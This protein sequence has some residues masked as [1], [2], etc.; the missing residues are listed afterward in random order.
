MRKLTLVFAMVIAL[1][2]A[3]L[4][5]AHGSD[6]TKSATAVAGT[7]TAATAANVETSTCTT[8]D[9]KAIATT[10][11]TYTGTAAGS[12]D[13]TGPI[14]LKVRSLINTTDNVGVV[15]GSFRIDTAA[16]KDTKAEFAA[17]YDKGK[18][19]GLAE[20]R[21]QD[22]NVQLLANLSAAFTAATGFAD[23][24]LGG[25]TTGGSAVELGPGK[26]ASTKKETSSARG[27]V[28]AVSATSITVA[29]LTCAVPATFATQIAAVKVNDQL[30]IRCS[31][32]NNVNTLAK[33]GGKGGDDGDKKD[34]KRRK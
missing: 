8:S 7:F 4:A 18:L 19:G 26:C 21:V 22:N 6:G 29:G 9:G 30:S 34:E 27:A 1:V 32:V 11:A 5:V 33:I 14:T 15:S 23:G 28:S 17:V 10:R 12:P 24:K 16:A 3:G 20:G 13:L 31:L 25:A 2:V